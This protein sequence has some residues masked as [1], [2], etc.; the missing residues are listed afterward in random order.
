MNRFHKVI[1]PLLPTLLGLIV[2]TLSG[3]ISNALPPQMRHQ[4][5][6]TQTGAE[7]ALK[8]AAAAHWGKDA[9]NQLIMVS[10]PLIYGPDA[11]A[12][13][14]PIRSEQLR[15]ALVYGLLHLDH[16]PHVVAWAPKDNEGLESNQWLLQARMFNRM[17][18]RLPHKTLYPYR[19][20][21]RFYHPGQR[22][23]SLETHGTFD[24]DE[25]RVDNANQD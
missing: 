11:E 17:P 14:A 23:L 20:E 18:I 1:R 12:K 19:L 15:N 5:A 8:L 7:M 3:C 25:L 13:H 16:A 4:N 22:P 10:P 24:S 21:M 9:S 6:I 2:L